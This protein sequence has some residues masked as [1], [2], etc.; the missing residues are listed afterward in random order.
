[1]VGQEAE[2]ANVRK[3]LGKRLYCIF[4]GRNDEAT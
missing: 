2:G 1:M 3:N 4:A